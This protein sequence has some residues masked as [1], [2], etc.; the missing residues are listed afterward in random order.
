MCGFVGFIDTKIDFDVKS[1]LDNMLSKIIQRGPDDSGVWIADGIALGHQR[2][3]IHDL[4]PLGHQPMHSHSN[5]YV[6]AFNGEIYNFESLREE[7]KSAGIS[8]TSSSDTEVLLACV[9]AWGLESSLKKFTGMFAFALWDKQQSK[10]YL[11]R[12]RMG[13]KPLYY[14]TLPNS[15]IFGSQ[16]GSLTQHPNFDKELDRN[17]IGLYLRHG[18]IPAPSS[19]Y[20]NTKKL[21]PGSFITFHL[22]GNEII[23]HPLVNYWSL[24]HIVENRKNDKCPD[25]PQIIIDKLDG[26]INKSVELQSKADVPLGAFLSGGIDSSL[27]TAYMQSQS[28]VPI[29]TF[30]IG[31]KDPKFNEAKFAKEIANH[32]GTSHTE[33]YIDQHDLLSVIPRLPVIYDEPFADSSQLPTYIVG[34]LAKQKVTV[35]LSGDGGDELFCGYSRYQRT[36]QRWEKI[37]KIPKP[38]RSVINKFTNKVDIHSNVN[39][40]NLMGKSSHEYIRSFEYLACVDFNSFYKRSVST[41]SNVELLVKGALPQLTI[42][43][44]KV[45]SGFYEHMMS[46]DTNQYLPD[47]ILA[48]VDRAFMGSSLEGRIPLLDHNIVEFA[49]M[50]PTDLHRFDG[51]GKYL[52]RQLLYKKVP[53]KLIER[54]KMGFA[55]PLDE[56]LREDLNEWA[57][58]LLNPIRLETDGIFDV[59]FVSKMWQQHQSN[60]NNWGSLLWSILMFNAWLDEQ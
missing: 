32:L 7:L 16:L 26:L 13:E 22:Y 59:H 57:N 27:I 28:T 9:G 18:Y 44:A 49:K 33:H 5:R 43:D 8:F 29:N 23:S 46:A 1:V 10:L 11:A 34:A 52:L 17:A 56:W 48:K 40:F 2:L 37:K 36:N 24:N 15:I 47:D 6:I 25:Q 3:S 20:K 53:K 39:N 41:L 19:V 54:P 45:A 51:K 21:L 31:F 55:I 42:Y 14:A 35:A 58:N 50:I 30:T 38:I 4:S 60:A 12:D